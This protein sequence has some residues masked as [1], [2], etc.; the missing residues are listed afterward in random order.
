[1]FPTCAASTEFQ[2]LANGREQPGNRWLLGNH[3]VSEFGSLVNPPAEHS[4]RR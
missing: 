2:Q 1:M 4:I 3:V